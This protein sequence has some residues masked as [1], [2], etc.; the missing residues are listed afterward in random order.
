M[1][2]FSKKYDV[3]NSPNVNLKNVIILSTV[4][5]RYADMGNRKS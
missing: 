2:Q 4:S 5:N 3:A 1:T